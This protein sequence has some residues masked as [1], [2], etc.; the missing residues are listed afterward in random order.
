MLYSGMLDSGRRKS[1]LAGVERFK[2]GYPVMMYRTNLLIHSQRVCALAEE[3]IQSAGTILEGKI[4]SEKARLIALV[5]DDLET[6][7]GDIPTSRKETMPEDE[8]CRMKENEYSAAE[9][10]CT[11][12]GLNGEYKH[13]LFNSIEKDCPEA[14]IVSYADKID[15]FCEST[16]EVFAGN[17]H[18]ADVAKEYIGRVKNTLKKFPILKSL[19]HIDH[20]FFRIPECIEFGRIAYS[21]NAHTFESI[22][23]KTGLEYYDIWKDITLKKI[24]ISPLLLIKEFGKSRITRI[25]MN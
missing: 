11:A 1:C 15:A 21:G 3:I 16:H 9:C 24:G 13:L 14:H 18:F 20:P 10:L 17:T 6:I 4:D 22:R 19:E 7:T 2:E 8:A 23:K 25:F 5:H 12:W